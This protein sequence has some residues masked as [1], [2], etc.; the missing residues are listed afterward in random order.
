MIHAPRLAANFALLSSG[1]L[2]S[3]VFA[4]IAFAYLARVLGPAEFGN[5]ELTLA[6]IVFLTLLVD[7]GLG[8]YGARELAKNRAL[9]NR[10]AT[11]IVL[12]RCALAIAVYSLLAISLALIETA[13]SV[14]TLLLLY[15][16]TLLG[17][18]GILSWIFQGHDLMH[19]VATASIIRWSLFTAGTLL[20]V[21]GP[22]DTWI[23]P[24]VEGSAIAGVVAFYLFGFRSRF[25]PLRHAIDRPFGLSIL[26]QALPIGGSELIWALKIYFATVLLGILHGG[27][28]VGWFGAAHRIVVSVHTFVWLYFFNLLPAIA[29]SSHG[30][31]EGLQ[32]LMRASMQ[33]TMW[34]AVF[35]GTIGTALAEPVVASVYGSQYQEAV[36]PFRI[37][38]WFIPLALVS[39]HYRY[40]LI[41]YDRQQLEFLGAACGASVNVILNL[42]L[43]PLYGLQGAAWALVASEGLI[44]ALGYYFVRR[45]ITPIP[46]WPHIYRPL[47][48]GAV[49][50]GALYF[51]PPINVWLT[52]GSAILFYLAL[53]SIMQPELLSSV[54]SMCVRTQSFQEDT[55]G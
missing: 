19:Y 17:L 53:L 14:K 41:A 47:M 52:G 38:I 28:G 29:R 2:L 54:R 36:A 23:V 1:E 21:R 24:L 31:V 25:G 30:T 13:S 40:V 43:I 35:L 51:L 4:V 10:L 45:T 15:G 55:S 50:G 6:V 44:W 7:S 32:R 9:V 8:P 46:S 49:L 16:L 12:I 3:K 33:L 27:P 26:R 18:P 34:L 11:H 42:A 5:L 22:E 20:Y 39:G 37:L 48:G